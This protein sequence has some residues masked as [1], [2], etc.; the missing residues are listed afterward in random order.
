M[1]VCALPFLASAVVVLG[2]Q[3]LQ[4][5][6][7]PGN[8]GS[9]YLRFFATSAGLTCL[10]SAGANCL[11]GLSP[12]GTA[13]GDLSGTFPNPTVA[14]VNGAAVP[15]SA[16]LLASNSSQ[17]LTS[18]TASNVYGLFSGT[19]SS[20]TYLSG[21]GACSTPAGSGFSN[22]MTTL[23]DLIAGGASG[24]PNRLGVGTNGYVL[25]AD[26]TQTYGL[27]WAAPSGGSGGMTQISQTV[28][29]SPAASV[30][31]TSI[32]GTY[33][34]LKILGLASSSSAS[35]PYDTACMQVNS[36]TSGGV[37]AWTDG[38]SN[39][40][41]GLQ[42][43]HGVSANYWQVSYLSATTSSGP[44]SSFDI[45]LPGY[46][47]TSLYKSFTSHFGTMWTNSGATALSGFAGGSQDSFTSAITQVKLFPCSGANFV[48]GSTFTLYGLQ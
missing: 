27:K 1:L 4:V 31:F 6:S 21:S 19:C 10:T 7:T 20:A 23:G 37:Y 11:A 29:G 40:T 36:I 32:P 12:G 18:A 38:T 43:D 8:P 5:I 22:P 42:A 2:Y 3:D 45:D 17:Q 48:T 41:V 26:S 34:Q 28:L 47:S 16:G 24:A 9:G 44:G 14:Q 35:T 39:G 15:A 33:S 25:T 13:G 30:T 46:S